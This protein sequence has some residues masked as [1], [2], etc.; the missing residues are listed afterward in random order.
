MLINIEDFSNKLTD[1]IEAHFIEIPKWEKK[2]PKLKDM[3]KLDKWL[4][5]LSN[6]TDPQERYNLLTG[7]KIMTQVA[8]AEERFFS[9]PDKVL[10]YIRA[11]KAENDAEAREDFVREE[12]RREGRKEGRREAI[13]E[14]KRDIAITMLNDNEPIEKIMKYTGLTR[15]YILNM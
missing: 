8:L 9:D 7:D 6:K 13:E 12:G 3:N 4:A 10:A 11:E 2:R 15:E 1:F 5:Y 14:T